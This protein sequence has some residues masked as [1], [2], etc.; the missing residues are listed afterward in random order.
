[1]AASESCAVSGCGKDAARSLPT[2]KVKE[3]LPDLS[4][5][6]DARRSH[7]CRDHYREFRKKTKQE[8]E[9]DRLGW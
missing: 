4:L 1:M 6:G 8:R 7:L 3:V 5:T 9:L 2:K